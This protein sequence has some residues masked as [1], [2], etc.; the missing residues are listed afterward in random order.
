MLG[1]CLCLG[2]MVLDCP[3]FDLDDD[4]GRGAGWEEFSRACVVGMQPV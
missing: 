1:I 2:G 4:D 3:G